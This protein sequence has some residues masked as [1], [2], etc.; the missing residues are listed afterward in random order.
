VLRS[1]SNITKLSS[2]VVQGNVLGPLFS[3]LFIIDIVALF[4]GSSC[5]PTCVLYADDLKLYTKLQAGADYTILQ[6]KLNDIYDW[7]VK[8]QLGISTRNTMFYVFESIKI[9]IQDCNLMPFKCDRQK[10][11]G[12]RYLQN[13]C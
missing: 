6:N 9:L 4:T 5:R 11:S 8:W 12:L 3:V 1:L 2:G 7:S 10:I 13:A